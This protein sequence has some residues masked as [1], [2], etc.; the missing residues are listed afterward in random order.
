MDEKLVWGKSSNLRAEKN[1]IPGDCRICTTSLWPSSFRSLALSIGV[2]P[3]SS[4]RSGLAPCLSRV[5]KKDK[6][7][8]V[9]T[10]KATQL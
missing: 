2:L 6:T 9:T 10:D 3:S 1:T 5:L 8:K 7:S 4:L